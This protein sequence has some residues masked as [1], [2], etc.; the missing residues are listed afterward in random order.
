MRWMILPLAILSGAMPM[1]AEPMPARP[2]EAVL[3]PQGD[4][5]VLMVRGLSPVAVTGSYALRV[6][7]GA[8]AGNQAVQRGRVHLVA[9]QPATFVTL[10]LTQFQS[11]ELTVQID[12]QPGYDQR[13]TPAR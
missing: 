11:A 7:S 2:V 4:M 1:H 3:T 12:G 5:D 8:H 9:N 6:L 13:V 10:R